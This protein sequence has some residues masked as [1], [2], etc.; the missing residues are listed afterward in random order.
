MSLSVRISHEFGRE[1][2]RQDY[3][4]FLP[5][6]SMPEKVGDSPGRG[7]S[8]N[9]LLGWFWSEDWQAGEHS[10]DEYIAAG[11]WQEFETI[12]EF[13][14]TLRDEEAGNAQ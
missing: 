13:L 11:E 5:E 7:K 6:V 3:S 14:H 9:R 10:V 8:E 12:E 2:Y 4:R 1:A